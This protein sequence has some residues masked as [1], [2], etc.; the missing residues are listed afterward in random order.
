MKIYTPV[1]TRQGPNIGKMILKNAILLLHPSTNAAYSSDSGKSL[2][3]PFSNHTENGS[4]NV[5][6]ASTRAHGV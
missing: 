4:V 5:V 2:K 1:A 6:Y 3:N